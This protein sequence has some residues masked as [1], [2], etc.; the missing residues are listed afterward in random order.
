MRN[1][2]ERDTPQSEDSMSDEATTVEQLAES[3]VSAKEKM[4]VAKSALD[5]AKKAYDEIG[6]QIAEAMAAKETN[7]VKAGGRYVSLR[8]THRWSIPKDHSSAVVDLLKIHK[9]ELVKETVHA[10]TLNKLAESMRVS[11]TP[12]PWWGDLNALLTD[13]VSTAVKVT[14]SKPKG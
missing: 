1:R 8:S 3:L 12:E 2:E 10:G 11:D 4:E 5:E 13:T 9:A 7:L 14:K 6:A